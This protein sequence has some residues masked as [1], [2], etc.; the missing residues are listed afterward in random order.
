MAQSG[1]SLGNYIQ[2]L[3]RGL[4]LVEL[5][6]QSSDPMSL[7]K[8]AELLNVDRSSAYRLL[9]TLEN[10]GYVIQDPETKRYRLGMEVIVLSRH[11]IDG[12]NLHAVAKPFLKQLVRESQESA[13]LAVFAGG[14][15]VCIDYEPTLTPL[16]VTN[17][18][19]VTFALHASA[20]GKMLLSSL[21][22]G[23]WM[24]LLEKYP[25]VGYTPR[26]ITDIES[27]K[28]HLELISTRGYAVD[29]EERYLGVRCVAVLIYGHTKK[30]IGAISIAGPTVRM[31][32]GR[33]P[34]VAELVKKT[35]ADISAAMGCPK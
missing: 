3:D 31:E 2:S 29:D 24:E 27:F 7:T 32:L 26:T 10:R 9:S 28:R 5:I 4:Q 16:A 8:L 1:T 17:E 21:D 13:N 35:A 33:V 20:I 34:Q 6:S 25:P 12:L 23:L 30:P 19:G 22:Q 15:A 14:Q 18:I 11:A